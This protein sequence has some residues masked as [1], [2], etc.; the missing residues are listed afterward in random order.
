MIF[1]PLEN[2]L[3]EKKIVPKISTDGTVPQKIFCEKIQNTHF[4]PIL[5]KHTKHSYQQ[6]FIDA[7]KAA[8]YKSLL[9]V[10]I[11]TLWTASSTVD[12][13]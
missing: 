7:R 11:C 1:K 13:N 6:A 12:R 5:F 3:S 9:Q 10:A 4:L 2:G 8:Q